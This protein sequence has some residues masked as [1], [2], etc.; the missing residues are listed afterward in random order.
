VFPEVDEAE[1]VDSPL[2]LHPDLDAVVKNHDIGARMK[3]FEPDSFKKGEA[4]PFLDGRRTALDV[5]HDQVGISLGALMGS[6]GGERHH[7][8]ARTQQLAGL[9]KRDITLRQKQNAVRRQAGCQ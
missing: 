7:E 2:S 5:E 4:H 6:V 1:A 9:V 3:V 8:L